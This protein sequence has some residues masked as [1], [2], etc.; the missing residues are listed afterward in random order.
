MAACHPEKQEGSVIIA[1]T[2]ARDGTI[3][4]AHI[5]RGSG[6]PLLDEAT[7]AMLKKA[8]PVPP[9]PESYHGREARAALPINYKLGLLDSMF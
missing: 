5:E 4:N 3:E 8:S 7:L 1:F 2:I 6:F 9:L